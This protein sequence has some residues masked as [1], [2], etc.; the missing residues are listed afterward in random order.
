[1]G[2][3]GRMSHVI[4]ERQICRGEDSEEWTD[5]EALL[6]PK[7]KYPDLGCCQGPCLDP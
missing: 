4:G 7:A 6:L 1:M 2:E 5:T 3:G